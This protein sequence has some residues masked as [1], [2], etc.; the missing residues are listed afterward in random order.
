M[1][2]REFLCPILSPIYLADR[3]KEISRLR[4]LSRL[5]ASV[6]KRDPDDPIRTRAQTGFIQVMLKAIHSRRD[7][8][9][10]YKENLDSL[11]ITYEE[12][13]ETLMEKYRIPAPGF[14]TSATPS[15]EVTG[16]FDDG[17]TLFTERYL[18]DLVDPPP[19]SIIVTQ[20]C[21]PLPKTYRRE[22][23]VIVEVQEAA[24]SAS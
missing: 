22:D 2:V 19:E 5:L 6:E 18:L 20:D 13:A 8:V 10:N 3:E 12:L 7:R 14:E 16:C 1:R 17:T 23:N 15:P 9:K 11:N 4:L 24:L 21:G